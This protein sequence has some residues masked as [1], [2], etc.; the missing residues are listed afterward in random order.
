MEAF[1]LV[2]GV[3]GTFYN[4]GAPLGKDFGECVTYDPAK[5]KGRMPGEC[6]GNIIWTGTPGKNGYKLPPPPHLNTLIR[7][8]QRAGYPYV[9]VGGANSYS[10]PKLETLAPTG[11]ANAG[12]QNISDGRSLKICDQGILAQFLL[13]VEP[14]AFLLC[15]GYDDRFSRPLG[16]PLAPAK[17]DGSGSGVWTRSFAGGAK[18][19]WDTKNKQGSVTWPAVPAPAPPVPPQ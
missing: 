14:G 12:G 13:A 1:R 11:P 6:S 2:D 9:V 7:D 4:K 17:E 16:K 8:N 18:A 19:S 3:N 5:G 10:N 15:N